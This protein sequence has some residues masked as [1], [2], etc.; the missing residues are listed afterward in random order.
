MAFDIGQATRSTG[1]E[2]ARERCIIWYPSLRILLR[3]DLRIRFIQ[4]LWKMSL[5]RIHIIQLFLLCWSLTFANTINDPDFG[6]HIKFRWSKRTT[7][8]LQPNFNIPHQTAL[9]KRGSQTMLEPLNQETLH[10]FPRWTATY[11]PLEAL[12]P[13][14]WAASGLQALYDRAR[15]IIKATILSNEELGSDI[16]MDVLGIS[17]KFRSDHLVPDPLAPPPF[18][19]FEDILNF[20]T[21]IVSWL[22]PSVDTVLKQ[23]L[24]G[25][26]G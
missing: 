3:R 23:A 14:Q 18:I 25:V 11:N 13:S 26:S 2:D 21:W 5:Q 10:Q 20:L 19:L 8:A 15:V 22:C 9:L 1:L 17:L 16:E 4:T 6:G 7:P 12:F 24:F